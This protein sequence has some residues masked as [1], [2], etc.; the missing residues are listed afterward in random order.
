MNNV[1]FEAFMEHAVVGAEV[2]IPKDVHP[3][4]MRDHI[5][6]KLKDSVGK[7]E[8]EKTREAILEM[9]KQYEGKGV[10]E[11]SALSVAK[12]LG[13]MWPGLDRM[14]TGIMG[15]AQID[16]QTSHVYL[17]GGIAGDIRT[18]SYLIQGVIKGLEHYANCEECHRDADEPDKPGAQE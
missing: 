1:D 2:T 18:A 7:V 17:L 5:L 3:S 9:L 12:A 11:L 6:Q 10:G 15:I 14:A 16:Q 4:Q 8:D 13:A